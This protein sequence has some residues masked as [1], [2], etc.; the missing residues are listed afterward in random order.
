MVVANVSISIPDVNEKYVSAQSFKA[1]FERLQTLGVDIAR[2]A[3]SCGISL[4]E[5][6][7]GQAG[8]LKQ[9][10]DL[11]RA[12]KR[13]NLPNSFYLRPP[14][15]F[16]ISSFGLIGLAMFSSENVGKALRVGT[17]YYPVSGSLI[18]VDLDVDELTSIAYLSLNNIYHL[19]IDL[20][21]NVLEE[22]LTSFLP[23]LHT[24]CGQTVSVTSLEVVYAEPEHSA[25]YQDRFNLQPQFN[26]PVTRFGFSSDVLSYPVISS[27]PVTAALLEQS[28]ETMLVEFTGQSA[29]LKEARKQLLNSIGDLMSREQLAVS[30]NMS[31]RSLRR[32]FAQENTSY[33]KLVGE[34]REQVAKDYLTSTRLSIEQISS[35]LGY[36][37]ATNFRRA[38]LRWTGT[39][40]SQYRKGKY[41]V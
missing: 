17:R 34:V 11:L 30:L 10:I 23:L 39:S 3:K 15:E 26:A 27:N 20:L 41:H 19:E 7:R 22:V 8:S 5:L 40:P 32:R 16:N 36:T 33:K 24:L 28:C 14:Q 31:E 12:L 35:L 9:K 18:G 4:F 29:L 25:L 13:Q 6:E 2:L 21:Q 38:F 1:Q 37:E